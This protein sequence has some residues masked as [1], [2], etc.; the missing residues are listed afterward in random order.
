MQRYQDLVS[1]LA[2]EG[3]S[4]SEATADKATPEQPPPPPPPVDLS[5]VTVDHIREGEREQH[6][7]RGSNRRVTESGK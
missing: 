5:W 2:P 1:V 3:S 4:M 6:E 7:T